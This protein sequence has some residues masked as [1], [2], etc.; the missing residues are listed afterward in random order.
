MFLHCWE[1]LAEI[2]VHPDCQDILLDVGMPVA[3]RN[4]RYNCRVIIYNKSIL[5]IR[6]KM[7][8]ANDG[9]YREM[10]YFTPWMSPQKVEQY[11]LPR[12]V[13]KITGVTKVPFG[14]AVISTPDTCL[15]FE[16]CQELFETQAPHLDMSLNG[17]E[18]MTNSSGSHH[19]LRKL[20]T[21]ISLIQEATRKSGGI[22]LYANQQGCDGDRLYYDGCAMIL[23]NGDVVAQGSQFSLNDV[24]QPVL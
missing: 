23:V 3:H 16:T 13:R 4:V 2:L 17:V 21:R 10:R 12:L 15:G 11:Y 7:W 18:I 5:L 8:L 14:D 6:P 19:E 1:K 22:Y 20:D 9:N 24:S